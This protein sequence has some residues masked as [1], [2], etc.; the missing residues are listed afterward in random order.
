MIA[1]SA[2]GP[3]EH[4]GSSGARSQDVKLQWPLGMPPPLPQPSARSGLW[5]PYD[6][7]WWGDPPEAVF[8]APADADSAPGGLRC[9]ASPCWGA[10]ASTQAFAAAGS[11]PAPLSAM[12]AGSY[13]VWPDAAAAEQERSDFPPFASSSLMVRSP[14]PKHLRPPMR[15]CR[16]AVT[17]VSAHTATRTSHH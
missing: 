5:Q 9:L 15:R 14:Q 8:V 4:L 17:A 3:A 6:P 13:G 10:S 7:P 16:G 11:P 2:A 1:W 12:R